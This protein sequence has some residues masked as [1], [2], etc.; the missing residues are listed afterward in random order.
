MQRGGWGWQAG[1]HLSGAWGMREDSYLQ[2]EPQWRL[3][4]R[5]PGRQGGAHISLESPSLPPLHA[6][7]GLTC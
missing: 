4:A 3:E 7:Q 5:R 2:K 6:L 1:G